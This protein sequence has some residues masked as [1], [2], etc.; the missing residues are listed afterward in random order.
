MRRQPCCYTSRPIEV[1]AATLERNRRSSSGRLVGAHTEYRWKKI[2]CRGI[3]GLKRVVGEQTTWHTYIRD[4]YT[5]HIGRS[6]VFKPD[7]VWLYT[8]KK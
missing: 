1:I 2:Q 7:V 5:A 6:D 8:I 4:E 3:K